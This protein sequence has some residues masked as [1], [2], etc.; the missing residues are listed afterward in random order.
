MNPLKDQ[1]NNQRAE[2]PF[3]RRKAVRVGGFQPEGEKAEVRSYN[4]FSIHE[5]SL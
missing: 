5:G 4:G 1:K 3:P 2:T